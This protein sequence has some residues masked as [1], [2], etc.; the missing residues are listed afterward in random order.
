MSLSLMIHSKMRGL[1]VPTRFSRY[2]SGRSS[3]MTSHSVFVAELDNVIN[4]QFHDY[5]SPA[6]CTIDDEAENV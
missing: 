2:M 1:V 5:S 6:Y 3:G 4:E